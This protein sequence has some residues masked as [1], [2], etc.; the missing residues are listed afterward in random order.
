[1]RW[2]VR[3]CCVRERARDVR[4]RLARDGNREKATRTRVCGG[5]G[6]SVRGN[7]YRRSGSRRRRGSAAVRAILYR[8]RRDQRILLSG[9]PKRRRRRYQEVGVG[10]GERHGN[11]G[12]MRV[13]VRPPA[14][15]DVIT[16]YNFRRTA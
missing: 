16:K 2:P 14:P 12:K 11:V 8:R 1:M 13:R 10:G 4:I 3:G 6:G 15:G 5:S 9:A 7:I